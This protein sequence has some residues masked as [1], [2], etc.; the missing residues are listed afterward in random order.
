MGRS[1]NWFG[2]AA[3]ITTLIVLP[4]SLYFPWWQLT[5]GQNLV[6]INSSP[7]NTN[8]ALFGGAQFTV[9]L[10]WAMNLI[11]ILTF[12]AAGII[13]LIYSI[14]PTKSYSKQ[15]LGF[16]YKKPLYAVVSFAVGIVAIVLVTG[17]L[18]MNIPLIG[19]KTV[20]LP[21]QLVSND[22]SITA[23]VSSGFQFPFYIAIAAAALCIV[24]R[25]YHRNLAK[26]LLKTPET[27]MPSPETS[28]A[29][30]SA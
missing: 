12:T 7:M 16:S 8:F 27:L 25:L 23:S 21:T 26:A 20:V 6:K 10:I 18:G 17:F 28:A 2:L 30:A 3:G 5:I 24:A 9:P 29:P 15:L 14:N 13:M 19:S 4:I 22:L 1:I 11:S